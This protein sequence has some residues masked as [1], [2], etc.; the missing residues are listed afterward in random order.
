MK[1]ESDRTSN[2]STAPQKDFLQFPILARGVDA[3]HRLAVGHR[4]EFSVS[5]LEPRNHLCGRLAFLEECLL[6]KGN[7]AVLG[8]PHD[9]ERQRRGHA[10][11]P[12]P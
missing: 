6:K 9:D 7:P 2:E 3:K 4:T 10:F 11:R 8:V 1:A 5:H 12:G